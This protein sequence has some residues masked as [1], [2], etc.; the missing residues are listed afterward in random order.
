[1]FNRLEIDIFEWFKEKYPLS[2][3]ANQLATAK[4]VSRRWT[5]VGFYLDFEVDN[6]LPRLDMAEYGGHF[7]IN[8]PGIESEDVHNNGGCLLWGKDGYADCL[9]MYA[10]GDYFKEEV[11][12]YRLVTFS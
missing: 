2:T 4:F 6:N 10:F 12:D 8:G 3:L 7:P 1:M 5:R 11:T 9:E